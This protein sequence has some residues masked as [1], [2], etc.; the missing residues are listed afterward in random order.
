MK[1][2]LWT[3]LNELSE[4]FKDFMVSHDQSVA[5]YTGLFMLGLLIFIIVFNAL[6]KDN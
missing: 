1:F 5:L 2:E 3:K 4:R 6:N